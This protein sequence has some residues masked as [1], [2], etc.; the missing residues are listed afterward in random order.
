VKYR[1]FSSDLVL[2]QMPMRHA[3]AGRG[4]YHSQKS[5]YQTDSVNEVQPLHLPLLCAPKA[6]L[7]SNGQCSLPYLSVLLNPH[8][9]QLSRRGVRK[10]FTR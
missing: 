10:R 9:S 5:V 4:S 2:L 3:L 1:E 6:C 7:L 8:P